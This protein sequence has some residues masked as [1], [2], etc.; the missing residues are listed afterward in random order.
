MNSQIQEI[1]RD[2]LKEGYKIAILNK[3]GN[4]FHVVTYYPY[5]PA[6]EMIKNGYS[7]EIMIE[8]TN[9][10]HYILQDE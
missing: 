9:A 10:R 1:Y 8:Q 6:M 5:G 4:R 2:V 7:I 3:D